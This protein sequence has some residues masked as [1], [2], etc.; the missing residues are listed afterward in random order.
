METFS[1]YSDALLELQAITMECLVNQDCVPFAYTPAFETD[2]LAIGLKVKC[3]C[4]VLAFT[5][6]SISSGFVRYFG[7]IKAVRIKP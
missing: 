4:F 2:P 1:F 6:R 5:F 3:L 7:R